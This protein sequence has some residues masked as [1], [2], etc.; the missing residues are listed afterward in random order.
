MTGSKGVRRPT[1]AINGSI[2]MSVGCIEWLGRRSP[3][4]RLFM[5]DRAKCFNLIS[6]FCVQRMPKNLIIKNTHRNR[7]GDSYGRIEAGIATIKFS[8]R[9]VVKIVNLI[10]KL[11]CAHPVFSP[12]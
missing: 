12:T 7:S 2:F 11:E 8:R 1:F 5:F 6:E 9:A 3:L 4:R 10:R